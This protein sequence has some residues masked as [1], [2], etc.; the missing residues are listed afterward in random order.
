M[1]KWSAESDSRFPNFN[2]TSFRPT[3]G[4]NKSDAA[5]SDGPLV[6][7]VHSLAHAWAAS[8]AAPPSPSG[9]PDGCIIASRASSTRTRCTWSFSRSQ[10][11]NTH[12][13]YGA[14]WRDM[15]QKHDADSTNGIWVSSGPC[16][17]ALAF[18]WMLTSVGV[19]RRS[20]ESWW[21]QPTFQRCG[22]AL[23]VGDSGEYLHGWPSHSRLHTCCA[24]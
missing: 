11:P 12:R 14:D 9:T 16:S 18:R 5:A 15:R 20:L 4:P 1:G 19:V 10:C 21:R 6:S 13:S 24:H 17:V 3:R 23:H 7:I 2:R 22:L 8:N